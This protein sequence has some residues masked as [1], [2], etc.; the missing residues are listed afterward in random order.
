[1][2]VSTLDD[3]PLSPNFNVYCS[4]D[5][6][7]QFMC[8]RLHTE[9]WDAASDEDKNKALL[10]ATRLLDH[11]FVW[12]GTP[13]NFDQPRDWPRYAVLDEDGYYIK[14]DSLPK[15]LVEAT[16]EL[17]FALIKNDRLTFDEPDTIGVESVK[18]GSLAVKF[19][20]A[21]QIN[22]RHLIPDFISDILAPLIEL[23]RDAEGG[24]Y[25]LVRS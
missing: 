20:N 15:Y 10:Y 24:I 13:V 9:A 12:R 23:D 16:A 14:H 19:E 5:R 25:R 11:Q 4:L 18:L 8:D 21:D 1:M 7:N 3:N 22:Q 17:A 6:A 2:A